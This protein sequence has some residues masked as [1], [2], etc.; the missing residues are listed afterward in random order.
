M[1]ALDGVI[2]HVAAGSGVGINGTKFGNRAVEGLYSQD[3]FHHGSDKG[4]NCVVNNYNDQHNVQFCD[5][6]GLTDLCTGCSYVQE[7]LGKYLTDLG[8][9]GVDG[10]RIDAAKHQQADELGAV[11]AKGP[12]N[13][14]TFHEVISGG[15][16]PVTPEMYFGIGSVTEFNYAR[17]LAPKLMSSGQLDGLKNFGTGMGLIPSDKAVVFI[18]NHDTQRGEA[19]LTYKNGQLYTLANVF[20]IAHPYGYPKVPTHITSPPS[21]P[22]TPLPPSIPKV[23]SSY[24]FSDHDAGPPKSAVHSGSSLN[25]G[26][27]QWECEHRRPAI[28]GMIKWRR[29]AAGAALTNW[30]IGQSGSA[31][32]FGRGDKAFVAINLAGGTWSG[33]SFRTGMPKGSYCNVI[34]TNCTEMITVGADGNAQLNVP[35]QGAVA[36]HA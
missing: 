13:H 1:H 20:M 3:D 10:F 2:N 4:S 34:S 7:T 35:A 28:A 12:S 26:K 24:D 8:S 27:G 14:F 15:G 9:I 11:L 5:L 16:E 33:S 22:L 30:Q 6:V 31:V 21:S 23:M 36:F 18:D 17:T 29:A 19:K 32:A 25:C